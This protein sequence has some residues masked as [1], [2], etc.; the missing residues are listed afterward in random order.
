M[1]SKDRKQAEIQF[2]REYDTIEEESGLTPG[3][4]T[5]SAKDKKQAVKYMWKMKRE[6][7]R[8]Q[9]SA[10]KLHKEY[11]TIWEELGLTLEDPIQVMFRSRDEDH[12][13][14]LLQ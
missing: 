5:M 9:Q 8:Q 4:P 12:E 14:E 7:E 10:S 3:D 11:N 6:R 1:N 13:N 2:R